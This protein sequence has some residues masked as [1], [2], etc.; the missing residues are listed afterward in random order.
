MCMNNTTA[1]AING[2]IVPDS[3]F[4]QS[5]PYS[6]NILQCPNPT[7]CSFDG[8]QD[9]LLDYQYKLSFLNPSDPAT[10]EL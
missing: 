9:T 1:S 7:S 5:N 8:R 3:E 6:A 2:I 10:V 4:Y